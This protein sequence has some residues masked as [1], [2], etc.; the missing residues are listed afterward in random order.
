MDINE[1]KTMEAMKYYDKPDDSVLSPALIAKKYDMINNKND[2]YMATQK[3]DGYWMMYIR[4]IGDDITIRGRNLNKNGEYENYAPKV[5][6]I[7]ECMKSW[8]ENTVILGEIC[9]PELD[10]VA[11]DVGVILRCL[12]PTAISRQEHKK[13]IVKVFDALMI[14]GEDI[15]ESGYFHRYNQAKMFID[16]YCKNDPAYFFITDA[17][18]NDFPLFADDI[19][20]RGGEGCVIQRKDYPYEAGKRA[21]WK[22]LKLKQHLPTM[23]LQV[24]KI[25]KANREYDGKELASWPYWMEFVDGQEKLLYKGKDTVS[26]SAIPVTSLYYKGWPG[27]FTVDYNGNEVDVSSGLT[28]AQREWLTTDEAKNLMSEGKLYALV[29]AMQVATLGGLRHPVFIDFDFDK[30][31]PR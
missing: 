29:R 19:I 30:D 24:V 25:N 16:T 3:W 14:A 6:H 15:H 1:F 9:W 27:S 2:D 13:L 18:Y 31:T 8:P 10:K 12:V 4:G 5:P 28:D 11:T 7:V 21:A 23:R 26:V 17:A 20:R 22:T